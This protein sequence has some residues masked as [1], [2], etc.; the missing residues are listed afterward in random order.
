MRFRLFVNVS[1]PFD[2]PIPDAP[3]PELRLSLV[4]SEPSRP[5]RHQHE[6][7]VQQPRLPAQRLPAVQPQLLPPPG[8]A[9]GLIARLKRS[10]PYRFF[11]SF[12][13]RVLC[14][15]P[16]PLLAGRV[17]TGGGGGIV[18]WDAGKA[19]YFSYDPATFWVKFRKVLN[20]NNFPHSFSLP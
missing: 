17:F 14:V 4:A 20:E 1:D 8:D 12:L 5:G 10:R 7:T 9:A 15:P 13:P 3:G 2:E 16:S 6:P 18:I 11:T 19:R